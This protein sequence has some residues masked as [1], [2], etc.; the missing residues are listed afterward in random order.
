MSA[1]EGMTPD[2]LRFIAE[3]V[4]E[5]DS[6][7]AQILQ[8]VAAMGYDVT[9]ADMDFVTGKEV[10]ADLLKWADELDRRGLAVGQQQ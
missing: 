6:I 8:R 3:Y 10:Q 7:I 1:P 2:K 9:D 5:C 4:S